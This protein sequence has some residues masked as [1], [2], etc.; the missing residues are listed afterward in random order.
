MMMTVGEAMVH[1][2]EALDAIYKAEKAL[3]E[4]ALFHDEGLDKAFDHVIG[5]KI[6]LEQFIKEW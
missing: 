5:V 2:K 1:V 6:K 4:T 3:H